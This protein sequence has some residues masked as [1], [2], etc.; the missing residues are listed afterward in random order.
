VPIE[1]SVTV[2]QGDA[3]SL[4]NMPRPGPQ[5]FRLVRAT[6]FQAG[7]AGSI[8]FARSNGSPQVRGTTDLF[9]VGRRERSTRLHADSPRVRVEPEA[10]TGN[11]NWRNVQAATDCSPNSRSHEGDGP[12]AGEVLYDE[13]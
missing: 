10:G 2:F 8:P 11:A 12:P 5:Q 3:R 7:H 1:G 13:L 9:R 4:A 6:A